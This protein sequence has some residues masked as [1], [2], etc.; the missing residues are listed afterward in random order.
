MYIRFMYGVFSR[1]ITIHTVINGE[2]TQ[3]WPTLQTTNPP[4]FYVVNILK[5]A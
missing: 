5:M 1:E 2:H 4:P 3:F